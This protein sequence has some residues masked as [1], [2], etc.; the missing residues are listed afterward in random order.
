[1]KKM[2]IALAAAAIV[3]AAAIVPPVVNNDSKNDDTADGLG[4]DIEWDE[5]SYV[6]D[7]GAYALTTSLEGYGYSFFVAHLITDN[8]ETIAGYA[9]AVGDTVYKYQDEC[10]IPCT[11]VSFTEF[12]TDSAGG[13]EIIPDSF[14][15]RQSGCRYYMDRTITTDTYQY[16]TSNIYCTICANDSILTVTGVPFDADDGYAAIKGIYDP[17]DDLYDYSAGQWV[18]RHG[19]T[20]ATVWEPLNSEVDY[21][22]VVEMVKD[23]L[24]RQDANICL[25]TLE[26]TVK[27]SI[28]AILQYIAN[29]TV[30]EFCGYSLETIEQ[31][32]SELGPDDVLTLNDDGFYVFTLQEPPAEQSLLEKWTMSILLGAVFV[33]SAAAI[34]MI[35]GAGLGITGLVYSAIATAAMSFTGSMLSDVASGIPLSEMDLNKHLI[36]LAI[37]AITGPF[38]GI[39]AI[40]GGAITGAISSFAGSLMNGNDIS[41]AILAGAAGAA[42]GAGLGAISKIV[43]V[44]DSKNLSNRVSKIAMKENAVSKNGYDVGMLMKKLEK[45]ATN[46]SPA[47]MKLLTPKAKTSYYKVSKSVS[48]DEYKQ[49]DKL[50]V[51]DGKVGI[52][53]IRN[54]VALEKCNEYNPN[55]KWVKC[56][57][58]GYI[59]GKPV[60]RHSFRSLDEPSIEWGVKFKDSHSPI[61]VLP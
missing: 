26:T 25:E 60:S 23:V 7:V 44:M 53:E 49:M 43:P 50:F 10:W 61:D 5:D 12:D 58:N 41:S 16:I 8:N 19:G 20:T 37:G 31:Y 35:P 3:L 1:M 55:S 30:P 36:E 28:D 18:V 17:R 52:D 21:A 47:E 54:K 29:L 9:S 39:S 6:L 45:K 24:A 32:A 57:S 14:Y 48:E 13:C 34:I 40:T 46:P 33:M 15:E 22:A 51:S 27:P 4:K 11:F 38:I 59:D 2:L 42:F 56:Y